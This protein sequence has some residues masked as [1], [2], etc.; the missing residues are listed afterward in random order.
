MDSPMPASFHS[1]FYDDLS[2][3]L[4]RDGKKHIL[5]IASGRLNTFDL[6]QDKKELVSLKIPDDE[7]TEIKKQLFSFRSYQRNQLR[8]N[9]AKHR[10]SAHID[11]QQAPDH[12]AMRVSSQKPLF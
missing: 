3:G 10:G 11:S 2:L 8:S 4:V 5:D 1:T 7:Q 12:Q 6:L 9:A